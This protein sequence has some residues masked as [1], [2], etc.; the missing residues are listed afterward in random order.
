VFDSWDNEEMT[1]DDDDIYSEEHND[2]DDPP[3]RSSEPKPKRRKFNEQDRMRFMIAVLIVLL[4]AQKINFIDLIFFCHTY[5][6]F[7][8][9]YFTAT[10]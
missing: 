10:F 2:I 8:R 4:Y 1:D 6:S 7:R 5:F 3:M 9:T